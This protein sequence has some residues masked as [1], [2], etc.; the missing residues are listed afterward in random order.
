MFIAK[1]GSLGTK[2]PCFI[3]LDSSLFQDMP[4]M[5]RERER[6]NFACWFLYT[7]LTMSSSDHEQK[8][9]QARNVIPC[10]ISSDH[11]LKIKDEE[12]FINAFLIFIRE[13]YP[14]LDKYV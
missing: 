3:G 4:L 6:D 8:L 11:R 5:V 12:L 14:L 7:I 9:Y 13:E 1:R 2:S 10:T